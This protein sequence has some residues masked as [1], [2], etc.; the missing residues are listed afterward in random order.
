MFG[1]KD[2]DQVLKGG[3]GGENQV[4]MINTK[5]KE[6]MHPRFQSEVQNQL[7]LGAVIFSSLK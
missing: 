1:L 7:Y 6:H 5:V 2:N 3:G 4:Y